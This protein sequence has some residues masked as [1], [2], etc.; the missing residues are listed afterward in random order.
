MMDG[1]GDLAM[2][3]KR[4]RTH[5]LVFIVDF[6]FIISFWVVMD[7]TPKIELQVRGKP[8]DEFLLIVNDS[9]DAGAAR[10]TFWRYPCQNA[11]PEVCSTEQDIVVHGE[12]FTLISELY[13]IS[14][15]F[16]SRICSVKITIN[17][18]GKVDGAAFLSENR[19]FGVVATEVA[20]KFTG[21]PRLVSF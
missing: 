3:K 13:A 18:E 5:G 2:K 14:C 15:V 1:M 8:N 19:V 7:P 9:I 21:N 4:R 20:R 6:L 17:D 12:L 16:G 10:G 11:A